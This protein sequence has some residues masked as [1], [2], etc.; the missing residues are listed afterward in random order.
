MSV[1][2]AA[3]VLAPLLILLDGQ[4]HLTTPLYV[5]ERGLVRGISFSM[6]RTK[7]NVKT[8]DKEGKWK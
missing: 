8:K 1:G 2:L 7:V 4:E 5:R 6:A 3:S